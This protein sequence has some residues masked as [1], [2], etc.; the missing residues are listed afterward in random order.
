M[1]RF[2]A[3]FAVASVLWGGAVAYLVLVEGLAGPEPASEPTAADAPEA[4]EE[5]EAVPEPERRRRPRRAARAAR[6]A[7]ERTP[8]GFATTG[9]DL[10]ESE[11]RVVSMEGT[12]GE[13]QLNAAQ[14]EAGF[15]SAMGRIRRCLVL[16]AG[17][18]PVTGRITFGLRIAPDGSVRA[19]Q[20]TG[21][22]AATT[23]D[24]GDCLRAAA[25]SIRFDSFDGPETVVRYPLTLE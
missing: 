14:I 7:E 2:W 15:D 19:V 10:G 23:G 16:M 20:L 25:R 3:G 9:D 18:D 21:P 5:P 4:I 8:T 24:A 13:R 1:A 17:S 12:G 11:M 6:P 22:A